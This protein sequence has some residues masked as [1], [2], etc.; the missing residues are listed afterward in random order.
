MQGGGSASHGGKEINS[1]MVA[2]CELV[3]CVQS[4]LRKRRLA[5][6][7]AEEGLSIL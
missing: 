2:Q 3:S 6:L 5:R 4:W 7:V 1:K